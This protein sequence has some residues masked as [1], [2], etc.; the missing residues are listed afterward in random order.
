MD[1]LERVAASYLLR[2][3]GSVCPSSAAVDIDDE[4]DDDDRFAD[5]GSV[6]IYREGDGLPSDTDQPGGDEQD[7]DGEHNG[8]S[9]GFDHSRRDLFS[10]QG[11][12]ED[13]DRPRHE[14]RGRLWQDE[15]RDEPPSARLRDGGNTSG[16]SC[17]WGGLGGKIHQEASPQRFED[18]PTP[19]QRGGH[20]GKGGA[21]SN[22]A[23]GVHNNDNRQPN[24]GRHTWEQQQQQQR[25]FGS[26][27]GIEQTTSKR[28][29]PG[30]GTQQSQAG[31]GL[32]HEYPGAKK[33]LGRR[34][35]NDPKNGGVGSVDGR[36]SW[37]G[38]SQGETPAEAFVIP[39]PGASYSAKIDRGL[40]GL[41][42][43]DATIRRGAGEDDDDVVVEHSAKVR[44]TAERLRK[45]ILDRQAS[46]NRS[47]REVFGHFDRR[48]CGYVNVAEMRDALVDLR[49]HLSPKEGQVSDLLTINLWLNVGT[50]YQ[51][52][53]ARAVGASLRVLLSHECP[54]FQLRFEQHYSIQAGICKVPV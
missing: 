36:S 38:D 23:G 16:S 43:R 44:Q 28:V 20:G 51:A 40:Q 50:G 46:A 33:H 52:L 11:E 35:H 37:P 21:G 8:S 32:A 30:R 26:S 13:N 34:N 29:W 3:R 31:V 6:Y 48:R 41:G 2:P 25:R 24:V 27:G 14:N 39:V 47:I 12:D 18:V 4:D 5:D 49:L 1:E 15:R 53:P 45:M 19:I 7:E 17:N 54:P 42:G 10:P 9:G 22:V